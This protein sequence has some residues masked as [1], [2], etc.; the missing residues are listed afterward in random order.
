MDYSIQ[1][2]NLIENLVSSGYLRTPKIIEALKSTPRENFVPDLQKPSAYADRPLPIGEDQTISAPHMVALMTEA[3]EVEAGQ[4][5][6]EVGAGSGYQAAIL[7]RLVGEAGTVYSVERIESLAKNA[8]E[9]LRSL[10]IENVYVVAGDGTRG[11]SEHAPYDRIIVTAAAP[12]IPKALVD[13]LADGGRLLV[14]VGGRGYQELMC[15]VKE[16]CGVSE[17]NL[18][19]CVFVPL[20]GE[21]GW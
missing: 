5:V 13:Q 14:P 7:G 19:G 12:R 9:N 18:G 11:L 17:K 16:G 1:R 15:V 10:G 3:L 21:D 20:I 4:R 8:E 2:E 6:L